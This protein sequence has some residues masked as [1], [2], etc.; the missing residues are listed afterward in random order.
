MPSNSIGDLV[1]PLAQGFNLLLVFVA[2]ETI[3]LL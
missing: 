2:F 3:S 1:V